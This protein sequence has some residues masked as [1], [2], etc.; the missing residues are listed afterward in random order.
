ME[1]DTYTGSLLVRRARVHFA[2]AAPSKCAQ[3]TLFLAAFDR[4]CSTTL[5]RYKPA[6]SSTSPTFLPFLRHFPDF[7]SAE[8]SNFFRKTK[9]SPTSVVTPPAQPEDASCELGRIV[10]MGSKFVGRGLKSPNVRQTTAS[11]LSGEAYRSRRG[12]SGFNS[13]AGQIGQSMATAA[14]CWFCR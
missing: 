10:F 9:V 4:Y 3:Q 11:W 12:R 2:L 6:T 14:M 8:I 1:F 7:S 5:V 13:P